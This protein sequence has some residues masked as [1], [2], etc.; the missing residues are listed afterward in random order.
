MK[1][2]WWFWNSIQ[3]LISIDENE[4]CAEDDLELLGL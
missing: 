4:T 1:K 3:H 2:T